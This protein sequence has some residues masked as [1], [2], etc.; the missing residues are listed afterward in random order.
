MEPTERQGSRSSP[1][2]KKRPPS[3]HMPKLN[4]RVPPPNIAAALL[5]I[6]ELV[7]GAQ[8]DPGD[9]QQLSHLTL[10]QLAD[11]EVT[12][13]TKEPKEVSRTPAA[14]YVLTS[15]DIRRSGATSIPDLLRLVPGVEVAR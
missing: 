5:L 7:K 10:Q 3:D 12:T 6:A 2:Q 15:E 11:I 14:I 4:R 8:A 1:D 9:R 13:V